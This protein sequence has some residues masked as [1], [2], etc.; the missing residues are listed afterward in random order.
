[1]IYISP[2]CD[3][4]VIYNDRVLRKFVCAGSMTLAL[5]IDI[6]D[7]QNIDR[8]ALVLFQ[9]GGNLTVDKFL[10]TKYTLREPPA[11]GISIV[12]MAV[13]CHVVR[14]V[15]GNCIRRCFGWCSGWYT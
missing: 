4:H 2:T 15:P 6:I 10:A 11:G 7:R 9:T 8:H 3:I 5:S 1:M 12:D 13:T 14:V